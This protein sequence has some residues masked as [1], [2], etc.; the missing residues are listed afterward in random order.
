M[1]FT[2]TVLAS[3]LFLAVLALMWFIQL[4]VIA[5]DGSVRFIENNPV[6]LII[7][8]VVAGIICIFGLWLFIIQVLKLKERRREDERQPQ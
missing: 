3:H 4:F 5:K 7:E 8:L 1:K 6:I 2:I